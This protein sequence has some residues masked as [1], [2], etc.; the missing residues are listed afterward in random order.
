MAAPGGCS[1]PR[2]T[3]PRPVTHN[4]P[5]TKPGELPPR[6]AGLTAR[7]PAALLALGAC[8]KSPHR[9]RS[10]SR[11]SPPAASR[12]RIRSTGR[13]SRP[14]SSRRPSSGRTRPRASIAGRRGAS[15]T[16]APRCC[17]D[18]GARAGDRRRN[19]WARIKQRSAE[20]DAEVVVAG[21]GPKPRRP[22]CLGARPHPHVEGPGRRLALLSRGA[23]AVPRRPCR[24]RRASAGASARSTPETGRRSCCRTC[25]CAATAT[26]SR[27]TAACSGLD[28][29]Y[30]NDKGAYAHPA[31]LHADGDERREDHHLERLQARATASSPSGCSRRCRPTAAT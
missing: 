29:D 21:V 1:G 9:R 13:C 3:P 5:R 6:P 15:T 25:R 18:G 31:G 22:S 4:R 12:S 7:L 16:P 11:A 8:G 14:R 23:A 30:G 17:G 24:I 27:T 20:R 2:L 26:P 28:V 19:D 10:R